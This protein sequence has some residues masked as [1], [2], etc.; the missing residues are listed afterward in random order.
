M[1]QDERAQ[2]D[3]IAARAQRAQRQADMRLALQVQLQEAATR[4][5]AERAER[6]REGTALTQQIAQVRVW[7]SASLDDHYGNCMIS[8][9]FISI[10]TSQVGWSSSFTSQWDYFLSIK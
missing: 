6:S 1:R 4:R 7:P 3:D 5:Q 10:V 2:R 8:Y 9:N